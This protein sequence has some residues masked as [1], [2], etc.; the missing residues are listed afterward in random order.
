VERGSGFTGIDVGLSRSSLGRIDPHFREARRRLG[1]PAG[2]AFRMRRIGSGEHS[3]PR[4][5]ALL[6][7]TK[8]HVVGR[9]Q[10]KARV[11]VLYVVEGE[12]LMAVAPG[13]LNRAEPVREMPADTSAS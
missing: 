6:G 7:Q 1:K 4:G 9:Q 12:E 3:L 8:M 2:K 11:M 5:D 13:V 10:A